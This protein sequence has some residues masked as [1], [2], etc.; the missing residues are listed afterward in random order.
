MSERP[1]CDYCG[2]KIRD[3]KWYEINGDVICIRCMNDNFMKGDT[4]YDED[5]D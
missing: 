5:Q 4:E 2:H 3:R 1:V